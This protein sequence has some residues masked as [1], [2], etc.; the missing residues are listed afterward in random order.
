MKLIKNILLSFL[1]VTG[2]SVTGQDI[3][4]PMSPPRLV[5]DFAGILNDS[6]LRQLEQK[7]VRFDDSSS[8]QIVVIIVKSLNGITKEEFADRVGEKWGVGQKGKN[9]GVVVLVKPKYRNEKGDARI[10]VGYGLEGVIPD[11]IAKRIMEQE[12]IPYFKTGDYFSGI[13]KATNTLIS[14]A[15][16]EFT[17]EQYKKK[18][19]GSPIGYLV[20]IIIIIIIILFMRRNSGNHYT[21][22]S[23]GTSLWTALWLAS[24]MGNRGGGGSWGDFRSGGGSFGGGGGGGFGGFGGGSFGGGGAGGSW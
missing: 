19:G 2:I 5:N 17:A 24:M 14:L 3:P 6:Q 15:K 16:G 4:D 13:D 18:T 7:L 22:G 9:N 10:S 21:T 23:K 12:M 11:A 8:S 20:P 1:L